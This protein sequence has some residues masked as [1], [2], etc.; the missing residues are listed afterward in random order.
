MCW[1]SLPSQDQQGLK[2]ASGQ[3]PFYVQRASLLSL[4]NLSSRSRSR[5]PHSLKLA[6]PQML[7]YRH[8]MSRL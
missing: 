5:H 7:V 4:R 3:G 2:L 1:K 8:S 6:S